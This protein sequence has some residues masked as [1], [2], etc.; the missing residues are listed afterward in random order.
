MQAKQ[1]TLVKRYCKDESFVE[2]IFADK[3]L[4]FKILEYC[5]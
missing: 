4:K 1:N 3:N 2:R 5:I